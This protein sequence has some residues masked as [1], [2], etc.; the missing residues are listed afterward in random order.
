MLQIV[1][2]E[3][4]LQ[5]YEQAL[6]ARQDYAERKVKELTGGKKKLAASHEPGVGYARM[7]AKCYS[8]LHQGRFQ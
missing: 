7:G 4:G 8:H 2:D 3:P 5:P 6:Q 1:Q